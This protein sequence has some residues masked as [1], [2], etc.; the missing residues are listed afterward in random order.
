MSD[1]PT[2]GERVNDIACT[3]ESGWPE[4]FCGMVLEMDA[5]R[6]VKDA[7]RDA[8]AAE[9]AAIVAHLRQTA[10]IHAANGGGRYLTAANALMDEA[11]AIERCEH[12][13][14]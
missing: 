12:S 14:R 2:A 3:P 4:L 11:D 8:A 13:D 7:E 6:I 1:F 10:D 5:V 9:R